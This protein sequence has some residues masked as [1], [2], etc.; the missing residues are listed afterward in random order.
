VKFIIVLSILFLGL[1]GC[2]S[3]KYSSM[4]RSR[5]YGNTNTMATDS[6]GAPE[7]V[8]SI[9]QEDS[10][11]PYKMKKSMER[12][13]EKTTPVVNSNPKKVSDRTSLNKRM[14]IYYGSLS[15]GVF[16]PEKSAARVMI[17]TSKYGGY[18]KSRNN[19]SLVLRIPAGK[20][21]DFLQEVEGYGSVRN[22][23][24][25]SQDITAKFVDLTMRLNNLIATR[26]R[27]TAILAKSKK[28]KDTL[29]V[30]RELSRVTGEI[31]RIKGSLR[32]LGNLV[33]FATVTVNF[34]MRHGEK[35]GSF[36][37]IKIQSPIQWVRYFDIITLFRN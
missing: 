11:S 4:S 12:V 6:A 9:S 27:L 32:M 18:L 8:S 33:S 25:H 36:T 3:R 13:A 29:A 30:E 23:S 2:S 19:N 34:R 24:I 31:E 37:K 1:S 26:D 20:F 35:K 22:R 14:I 28:V 16:N 15:I 17:L 21:F 7:S 5:S 10:S